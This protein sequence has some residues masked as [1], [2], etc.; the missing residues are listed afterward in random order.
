[1][2]RYIFNVSPYAVL[3]TETQTCLIVI[4]SE[5]FAEKFQVYDRIVKLIISLSSLTTK[6]QDIKV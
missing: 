6:Y 4:K 3:N 1:M 5:D 2:F